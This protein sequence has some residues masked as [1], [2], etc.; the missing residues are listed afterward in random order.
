MLDLAQNSPPK[1]KIP[2]RAILVDEK[3]EPPN[4]NSSILYITSTNNAACK[5]EYW[6]EIRRTHGWRPWNLFIKYVVVFPGRQ[7]I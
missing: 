5:D 6:P 4:K 3:Y 1:V 7:E 2:T